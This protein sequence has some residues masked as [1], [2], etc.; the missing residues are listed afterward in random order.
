[1]LKPQPTSNN[2]NENRIIKGKKVI[3][4]GAEQRKRILEQREKAKLRTNSEPHKG[5]QCQK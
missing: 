1:M 4:I 2:N 3:E 5:C